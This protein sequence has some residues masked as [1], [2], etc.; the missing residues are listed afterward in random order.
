MDIKPIV[1]MHSEEHDNVGIKIMQNQL[2]KIVKE[3][4]LYRNISSPKVIYIGIE[5]RVLLCILLTTKESPYN[6]I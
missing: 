2:L 6:C 5:C 3:R 1:N 4:V